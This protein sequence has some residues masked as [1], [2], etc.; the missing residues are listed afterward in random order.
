MSVDL[1][2]ELDDWSWSQ[3]LSGVQGSVE[4]AAA[5][6]VGAVDTVVAVVERLLFAVIIAAIVKLCYHV[7]CL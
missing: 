7:C 2:L 6:V 3:S 4:A 5:A 1:I